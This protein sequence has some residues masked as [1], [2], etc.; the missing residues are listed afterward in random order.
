MTPQDWESPAGSGETFGAPVETAA[1]EGAELAA[2]YAMRPLSLSEVLDRTFTIYRSRFWLFAGISS[3]SGAVQLLGNALNLV[4]QHVVTNR[5]GPLRAKLASSGGTLTSALVFMLAAAVT[6]AATVYALSE[7]YLGRGATVGD[8]IRATIKLWYRYCGIALW[9]VWSAIWLGLLL[10]VPALIFFIPQFGLTSL[11]WLGGIFIFLAVVGGMV[12]GAIA[13]IRNSLGVQAAVV[14]QS[15]V[16]ASMRRSKNLTTGTKGRIFVVLLVA[17]ALS[18]VGGAIEIPLAIV[19][20][21][22][23]LNPHVI[24]QAMLLAITFVTHT[25]V[26]PVALI[27]LSLVY[28]D[29]RVRREAFD[30]VMLMGGEMHAPADVPIEATV[31]DETPVVDGSIGNDGQI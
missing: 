10:A 3:L 14:E 5:Y 17:V 31:V 30:L 26:T 4:G 2:V 18:Y 21:R 19:I 16:R 29:Q 15:K 22:A 1:V 23:P 9:Q 6:Q 12:Y 7:V 28:F 20:A 8:S 27:G 11:A 13:Y 25:L 24:A